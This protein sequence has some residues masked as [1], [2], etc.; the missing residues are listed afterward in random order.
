MQRLVD[1]LY[2]C[3][4]VWLSVL[5]FLLPYVLAPILPSTFKSKAVME[6]DC[7]VKKAY[8][9]ITKEPQKCPVGGSMTKGLQVE[10][11]NKDGTPTE[12]KEDLDRTEVVAVKRDPGVKPGTTARIS[13][14]M[15][16]RMADMTSNW[17]YL[18]EPAGSGRCRI[19]LDGHLEIQRGGKWNGPI[20]RMITYLA[21]GGKKGMVEHLNLVAEATQSRRKWIA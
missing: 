8:E 19:T 15:E 12:W 20:F 2:S 14:T 7:D 4:Y 21:D 9:A 6:L 18:L 10:V 17:E 16:S 3:W 13:Q 1:S 5:M 11:A